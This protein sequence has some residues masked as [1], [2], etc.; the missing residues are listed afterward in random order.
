MLRAGSVPRGQVTALAVKRTFA[1]FLR[2]IQGDC[3]PNLGQ[4]L[5][6]EPWK[7]IASKL[8][9]PSSNTVVRWLQSGGQLRRYC[10]IR[11]LKFY[12]WAALL[13]HGLSA[14]NSRGIRTLN[15]DFI[16]N[17]KLVGPC[18][19]AFGARLQVVGFQP[20]ATVA[21]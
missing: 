4:V 1:R 16:S 13:C 20:G 12:S 9:G 8:I 14:D 10:M 2:I 19:L 5:G 11:R 18:L 7:S 6:Q 17:S 15:Y 21:G 3:L